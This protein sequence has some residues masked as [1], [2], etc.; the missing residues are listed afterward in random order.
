MKESDLF[1]SIPA[2]DA[3]QSTKTRLRKLRFLGGDTVL[4]QGITHHKGKQVPFQ[5]VQEKFRNGGIFTLLQHLLD[6]HIKRVNCDSQ[7]EYEGSIPF[8]RSR[9]TCQK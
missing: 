5:K 9:F 3:I 2:F 8:A 4:F 7:A 6:I 1:H